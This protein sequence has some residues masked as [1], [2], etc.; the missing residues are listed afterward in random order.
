MKNKQLRPLVFATLCV[1]SAFAL[2]YTS[3]PCGP[4]TPTAC[5]GQGNG[6][7]C[8][9]PGGAIVISDPQPFAYYYCGG[10]T[11]DRCGGPNSAGTCSEL[12][13]KV[14]TAQ[15]IQCIAGST[16]LHD[17]GWCFVGGL[18]APV[19]TGYD[20]GYQPCPDVPIGNRHEPTIIGSVADCPLY[21][22]SYPQALTLCTP[23]TEP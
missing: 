23:S 12:L 4:V 8:G 20:C 5:S 17:Y 16:V 10:N 2:A 22:G 15:H 1:A 21:V 7:Q 9:G 19:A 18:S 14:G 6:A 11:S 13:Y 3:A